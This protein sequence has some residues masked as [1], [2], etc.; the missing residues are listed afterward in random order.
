MRPALAPQSHTVNLVSLNTICVPVYKTEEGR[1]VHQQVR[2][3]IEMSRI[4][5]QGI[6]RDMLQGSVMAWK[7]LSANKVPDDVILRVLADPSKRRPSDVQPGDGAARH[8]ALT[9]RSGASRP[10]VAD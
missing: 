6:T 4:V 3:N 10:P 9:G 7:F 2:N 5:E 1:R 8:L